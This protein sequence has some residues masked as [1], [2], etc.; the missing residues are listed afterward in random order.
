MPY[1]KSLV[2]IL[3]NLNFRYSLTKDELTDFK[4][5]TTKAKLDHSD[6]T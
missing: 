6:I 3:S 1:N 4:I 5:K 2:E